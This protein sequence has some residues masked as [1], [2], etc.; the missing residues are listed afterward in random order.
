M[1]SVG[2]SS[3]VRRGRG[4]AVKVRRGRG[5]AVEVRRKRGR[6]PDEQWKSEGGGVQGRAEALADTPS[7]PSLNLEAN[8]SKHIPF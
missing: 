5:R 7:L 2:R 4:R 3:E 6:V 8:T 1:V